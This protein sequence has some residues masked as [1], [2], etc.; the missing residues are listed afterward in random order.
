M[1]SSVQNSR[2]V[3]LVVQASTLLAYK[4][5]PDWLLHSSKD[6]RTVKGVVYAQAVSKQ[7]MVKSIPR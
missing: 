2:K 5:E 7:I 3:M 4:V 6:C 1:L